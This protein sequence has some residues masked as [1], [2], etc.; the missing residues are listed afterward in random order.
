[1][2]LIYNS[3]DRRD[4]PV[5]ISNEFGTQTMLQCILDALHVADS[6]FVCCRLCYDPLFEFYRKV[7]GLMLT[8]WQTFTNDLVERK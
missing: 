8:F 4:F 1:M 6:I 3:R 7:D 2:S 5:S